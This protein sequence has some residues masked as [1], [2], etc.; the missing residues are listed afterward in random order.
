MPESVRIVS[1]VPSHSETI[2]AIGAGETLVGVT[3]YC[4]E[5]S[6]VRR[7]GLR[8]VGGTKNP[9][10]EEVVAR[11]PDF[12]VVSDEENRIEDV[13]EIA[14]AGIEIVE[15]S[16]RSVEDAAAGV[17]VLGEITGCR[18]GAEELAARIRKTSDDIRSQMRAAGPGDPRPQLFCPIWYRP[19]MSFSSDTYCNSVI[20]VCG[21]GNVY[22]DSDRGRYF[23]VSPEEAAKFGAKAALLPT[24]PYRFGPRHAE[25]LRQKI[26]PTAIVE[27]SA[28]TW[29]GARTPWGLLTIYEILESLREELER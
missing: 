6:S 16:P 1:L 9:R 2:V 14:N 7:L 5:A 10:V 3:R 8:H 19:W 28:L 15:V 25:I 20:E 23:E 24:E 12:V 13:S 4:L 22:A 27:G 21:F 17:L 18:K 11:R 29:Y 26:G